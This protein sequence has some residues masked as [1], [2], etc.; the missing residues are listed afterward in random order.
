MK[1]KTRKQQ[2]IYDRWARHGLT[3]SDVVP[4]PLK[5]WA[6]RTLVKPLA[7][8]TGHKAWCT[9]CG[10]EFPL[11]L[12]KGKGKH[13][14]VCPHC[15]KRLLVEKS[16][17]KSLYTN[18][19]FQ[20]LDV[21][22]EFQVIRMF[23]YE[24][25]AKVGRQSWT[26]FKHVYD[27]YLTEGFRERFRFSVYMKMF[28]YKFRDPFGDGELDLRSDAYAYNGDPACGW[29]TDGVYPRIKLQ[30][31]LEKYD[32]RP[33]FVGT[34]TYELI[35]NLMHS[36]QAETVWKLRRL[37]KAVSRYFLRH[38][39]EWEAG[40]FFRQ[41]CLLHKHGYKVKDAAMWFDHLRMLRD[42]D[43]DINNPKYIFPH[44]LEREHQ[45]LIDRRNRRILEER[46]REA[47]ARKLQEELERLERENADSE[48]N[49]EY[50]KRY[51]QALDVVVTKGDIEIRALQNV[52]DFFDQ[53][54]AL[55]QCVYGSSYYKRPNTLCLCV[56]VG[57]ERTE[58][59]E[60][61]LKEK[62]IGQCRG[63]HNQDSPRHGEILALATKSINKFV[64]AVPARAQAA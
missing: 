4:Q 48:T 3:K 56:R 62:E 17:K 37:H 30:P 21:D 31:W 32:I 60:L 16:Q 45:A 5:R 15:G 19:F 35:L 54:E 33:P 20:Q 53:G 52:Q 29:Y 14:A 24:H 2:E 10:K 8:G 26:S 59:V 28:Y 12:P 40:P 9:E 25:S 11:E 39:N 18:G 42:E 47:E 7:M 6:Y 63:L 51:G 61:F 22:G 44:N 27:L 1:I 64:K 36:T 50:R 58:T 13:Y 23:E 49:K 55:D 43:K 41:V 46:R 57:G 34:D 38:D